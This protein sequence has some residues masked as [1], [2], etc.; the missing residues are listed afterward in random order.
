LRNRSTFSY[1]PAPG[2]L[3]AGSSGTCAA[4]RGRRSCPTL[5]HSSR[6][7]ERLAPM[8]SSRYS[9]PSRRLP[10]SVHTLVTIPA[11]HRSMVRSLA[12]GS[13]L[14]FM[15]ETVISKPLRR[16]GP[17]ALVLAASLAPAAAQ[18]P[19]IPYPGSPASPGAPARHPS[20]IRLEAQLATLHPGNYHP[21]HP[22]H[23]Q[24][25]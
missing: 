20:C 13:G 21:V 25:L 17:V 4:S 23:S 2:S 24:Q 6:P 19:S 18:Q 8:A 15:N 22:G 1:L 10:G 16:L 14:C 11:L 5:T 3:S 12:S 9:N 7:T